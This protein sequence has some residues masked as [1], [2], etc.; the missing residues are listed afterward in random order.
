MHLNLWRST[1]VLGSA[2]APRTTFGVGARA[3]PHL[4]VTKKL[5]DAGVERGTEFEGKRR[6]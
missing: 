3:E 2:V 6:V 5:G 1:T 4:C